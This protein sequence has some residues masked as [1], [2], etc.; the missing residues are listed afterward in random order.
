MFQNQRDRPD[1]CEYVHGKTNYYFYYDFVWPL[2]V[3]QTEKSKSNTESFLFE[4]AFYLFKS[5]YFFKETLRYGKHDNPKELHCD[6]DLV[7]IQFYF[8][9]G[10]KQR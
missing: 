6:S 7:S 4:I 9:G 3:A 2:L 1:M 5:K 10:C 8:W